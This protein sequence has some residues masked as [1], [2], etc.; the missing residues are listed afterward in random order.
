MEKL[1]LECLEFL[2]KNPTQEEIESFWLD[3]IH[4]KTN[5]SIQDIIENY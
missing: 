4:K 5:D 3:R 2:D 1:K